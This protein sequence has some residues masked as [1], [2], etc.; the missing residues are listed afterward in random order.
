[1]KF[2]KAKSSTKVNYWDKKR[3]A[4]EL[5]SASGSGAG[6]V[7]TEFLAPGLQLPLVVR[8]RLQGLNLPAWAADNSEF[9]E[10]NLKRYGGILFRGFE[11]SRQEDF[12]E[13]LTAIGLCRMEYIEG[14]TPRTKLGDNIYTSTEYPADQS[15]ALHNELNY[16]TTW[17][18][19]ILF[20]CV[21]PAQSGGETPIADV[22]RVFDRIDPEVRG[23]FME[24][25]WMLMRNAGEGL[26]LP[27]QTTFH[28]ATRDELEEY[29]RRAQVEFE[30]KEHDSLR[31]RQVRPAVARHP[32]TGEW[33]WFNHV[34]FWH[35]SS[36]EPAVR[37]ALLKVL[38]E[39]D[40]PYNTY[41]GDGAQI[42]NDVVAGLRAA[43]D[44]ETIR[45]LWEK[46]DLLLLDNMLVA[47][48]RSTFAG[49]RRI[50]AAMGDPNSER[51]L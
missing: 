24:K 11:M 9:V 7:K 23:R 36:L 14:A 25:G 15:I 35:V 31:T 18:M 34:A 48:G 1:M 6:M 5:N 26:S 41:Y 46:G 44:A 40:L 49:A 20:F 4:I 33:V 51:G 16:V 13:F 42:P 2:E 43:Y 21:T 17:P 45:F 19:K 38:K 47:H 27:W 32:Q 50:L 29:C 22:R 10:S 8:P 28:A 3:R 39:E 12:A 37:E 30:W